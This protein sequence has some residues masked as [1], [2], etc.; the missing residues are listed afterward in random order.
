MLACNSISDVSYTINT[1]LYVC[2]AVTWVYHRLSAFDILTVAISI[3]IVT[4]QS[5]TR[6][7][8]GSALVADLV[9]LCL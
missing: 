3:T 8:Q 2:S 1:M 6:V 7:R 4:Y 9:M 5:L